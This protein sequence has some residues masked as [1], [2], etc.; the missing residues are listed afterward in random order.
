MK[1]FG[2]V[3]P[4]RRD[5]V[6]FCLLTTC[7]YFQVRSARSQQPAA[8]SAIIGAAISEAMGRTKELGA[9]VETG[10]GPLPPAV[11]SQFREGE[12]K[13]ARTFLETIHTFSNDALT[14]F[15]DKQFTPYL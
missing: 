9:L 7:S 13:T 2:R 14:P 15:I 8:G 3:L 6:A 11:I 4:S 10:T 12:I 5:V 1:M